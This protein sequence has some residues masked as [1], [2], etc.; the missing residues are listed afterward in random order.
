MIV[1]GQTSGYNGF[2]FLD[3]TLRSVFL[4]LFAKMTCICI[5]FLKQRF[6]Y[7]LC[8]FHHWL[9]IFQFL[10]L[11]LIL[12]FDDRRFQTMKSVGELFWIS[13]LS[14]EEVFESLLGPDALCLHR[15]THNRRGDDDPKGFQKVFRAFVVR[16]SVKKN[17]AMKGK[18]D[19]I[20][21]T[22]SRFRIRKSVGNYFEPRLSSKRR[23]PKVV[24]VLVCFVFNDRTDSTRQR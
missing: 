15:S 10:N 9:L 7:V 2:V 17:A 19:D 3:I 1:F 4:A 11:S 20:K 12:C 24:S 13:A 22:S 5:S 6:C 8:H 18:V 16:K 14:G 21:R 23:S